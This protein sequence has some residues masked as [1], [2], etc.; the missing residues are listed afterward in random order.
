MVHGTLCLTFSLQ[1]TKMTC[2]FFLAHLYTAHPYNI[3]IYIYY[4]C[5][6]YSEL[7]HTSK[8]FLVVSSSF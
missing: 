6:I 4:I 7:V 2:Y 1:D 8:R 5:I 3:I